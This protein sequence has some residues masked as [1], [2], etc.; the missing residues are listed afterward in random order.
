[1][2]FLKKEETTFFVDAPTI[3]NKTSH[4][5]FFFLSGGGWLGDTGAPYILPP[6]TPHP[7]ISYVQGTPLFIHFGFRFLPERDN[8]FGAFHSLL[9]GMNLLNY[10]P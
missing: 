6:P 10:R 4:L 3:P 8:L 2:R 7:R 5:L 9:E 1:M